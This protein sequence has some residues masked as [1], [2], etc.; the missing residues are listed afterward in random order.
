MAVV[1]FKEKWS[2]RTI[3]KVR[4]MYEATRGWTVLMDSPSDDPMLILEHADYPQVGVDT[5]SGTGVGS[6][7]F[8]TDVSMP[9]PLGPTLYEITANYSTHN[10]NT[11]PDFPDS[12]L[13]EPPIY[14]YS[15]VRYSYEMDTDIDGNRILNYADCPVRGIY[16][17]CSDTLLRITRN[18][19][20]FNIATVE[21]YRNKINSDSF[22]GAAPRTIKCN[23]IVARGAYNNGLYY[24]IVTYEFQHR[25]NDG[26]EFV[27]WNARPL[28]AGTYAKVPLDAGGFSEPRPI[29][30]NGRHVDY[31]VPLQS[32]GTALSEDAPGDHMNIKVYT[33]VPFTTAFN[34]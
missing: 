1:D 2:S 20:S 26:E 14:E 8:V 25:T 13:D 18:E 21:A 5:Y 29:E 24:Y 31:P 19:G 23:D 7:L 6:Y 15:S 34:F 16:K 11:A 22:M 33:A 27:D 12:P 10:V 4:T 28:N 9:R 32:D 30:R 3:R 17:E